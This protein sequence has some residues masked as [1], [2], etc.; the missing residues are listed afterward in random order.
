M[1]A[2][3]KN[4]EKKNRKIYIEKTEICPWDPQILSKID[5]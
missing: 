1:R 5:L 2:F 3:L 4:E